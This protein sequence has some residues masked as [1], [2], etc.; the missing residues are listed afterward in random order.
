MRAGRTSGGG[1]RLTAARWVADGVL[2]PKPFRSTAVKLAV[3][4][5]FELRREN[6]RL[7][8]R[9]QLSAAHEAFT[10]MGMEAF[11]ERGRDAGGRRQIGR[12]VDAEPAAQRPV[13]PA[14]KRY[15]PNVTLGVCL[16]SPPAS[17]VTI[18]SLVVPPGLTPPRS[19][20]FSLPW[21]FV[22]TE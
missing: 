22:V 6:R 18:T 12:G 13:D 16:E 15:G 1:R 19:R 7:D 3:K 4:T 5:L 20:L 10:S 21:L 17:A 14:S 2:S 11:A 8:A 9:A